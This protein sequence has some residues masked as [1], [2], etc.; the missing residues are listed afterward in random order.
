MLIICERERFI[1]FKSLE[2][3][4]YISRWKTTNVNN[5]IGIFSNCIFLKE[6]PDISKWNISK[7]NN[8]SYIFGNC[9]SLKELPNI[10]IFIASHQIII[11]LSIKKVNNFLEFEY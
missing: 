7:V 10:L 3:L 1:N 9:K 5:M 6:L 4:P 2:E 11:F 8:M